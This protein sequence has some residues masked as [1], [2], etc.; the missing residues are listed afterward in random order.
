[1]N[2]QPTCEERIESEYE[3]EIDALKIAINDFDFDDS[4]YWEESDLEGYEDNCQWYFERLLYVGETY[5]T[6]GINLPHWFIVDDE[7]TPLEDHP[8]WLYG[9]EI[10]TGGPADG[11]TLVCNGETIIDAYYYFQDWFDGALKELQGEDLEALKTLFSEY[12]SMGYHAR[13]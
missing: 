11:F 2:K 10:S 8:H 9:I 13:S 7:G 4:D 5:H 1:M 6:R 12:V 3:H